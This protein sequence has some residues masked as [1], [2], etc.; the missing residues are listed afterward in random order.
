MRN[1]ASEGTSWRSGFGSRTIAKI[2]GTV[3]VVVAV[4]AMSVLTAGVGTAISGALG[5]GFVVSI[6]G[7]AVGGQ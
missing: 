1:V 5:G 3:L 7:G 4:V 2:V 6:L